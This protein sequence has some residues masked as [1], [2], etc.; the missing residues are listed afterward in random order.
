M[1]QNSETIKKTFMELFIGTIKNVFIKDLF[2][3]YRNSANLNGGWRGIA[4]SGFEPLT[5]P[6]FLS[7][8]V[9]QSK[10]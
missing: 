10:L 4:G 9:S 6:G 5:L 3:S 8:W 7:F 2:I 1:S